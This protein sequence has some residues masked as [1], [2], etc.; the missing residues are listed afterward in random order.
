MVYEGSVQEKN[1]VTLTQYQDRI[2]IRLKP[3]VISLNSDNKLLSRDCYVARGFPTLA[4]P[5]HRRACFREH[6][7]HR[8]FSSL[9]DKGKAI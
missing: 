4:K 9:E 2:A 7:C 5:K 3:A 8:I 6:R 1:L